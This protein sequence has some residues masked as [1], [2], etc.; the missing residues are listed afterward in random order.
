M[1]PHLYTL[2]A[3]LLWETTF[4]FGSWEPGRTQ[5]AQTASFQV[6]GKGVNVSRMLAR[7]GAPTTAL[8]FPGGATGA[9]C[10]QWIRAHGVACQTF[11][12]T[13]PTRAGL[14]VRAAG[15]PE[16]TFLG[17]DVPLDA[18]AVRACAQYL[19]S[20]PDGD[21]LAVCGS[22]P[23][24]ESEACGPLQ[25][26]LNR[27]LARGPVVADTY[28]PPLAWLSERPL[29]WAKV[30]RVEFDA[31]FTEEERREPMPVRLAAS[32]ERWPVRA[33]IV[34][35]GPRPIW[36]AER[37]RAPESVPPPPVAEVSSTGSGDVLH[38]CLLHAVFHH[39]ETLRQALEQALPYAAANAAHGTVADF[40]LNNLPAIGSNA[41]R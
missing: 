12:V 28:G 37:G 7:L 35:D 9:D 4:T 36:I 5:R 31:L 1:I 23:G 33:W 21:V 27:R 6:G 25:A 17:P 14:V 18:A 15:R 11:P 19:D 30:N 41:R 39:R 8:L 38:A 13:M 32:L 20:C 34:T 2:T 26:A 40:P 29:A 10:E 16:T 22:V 24:W 3:N